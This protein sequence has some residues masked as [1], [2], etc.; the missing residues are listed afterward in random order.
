MNNS[1]ITAAVSM[2][3]IQQRLDIISDNIAN[4]NTA[5]YKSKG[6]TFE[7]TLTEVVKQQKGMSLT[8]RGTPLGTQAAYGTKMTG[9]NRNF[10]QGPIQV[11]DNPTDLAI[12]GNALFAVQANGQKAWTRE[13][14][15]QI[16]P[17]PSNEKL[18]YLTTA[19][20]YYVLDTNGAP[21]SI[22]KGAK[23]SIDSAGT[24]KAQLGSTS[25][26]LGRI[27]LAAPIKTDAL[28]QRADNL[29]VLAPGATEKD[30]LTAVDALPASERA[31]L[32]QGALEQSN[33]D[34]TT[35]MSTMLQ[36]QRAY[37]LSAKAL[38]SSD[39][40]SSLVNNLRG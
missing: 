30:V 11:T 1:M 21:I 35:E 40:M 38:T 39:T 29:Y 6:A 26:T 19:Q 7:D 8:G 18:A 13:G 3:S 17:D 24:V 31:S 36:V 9:V 15:F 34:L 5:G 2:G 14:D 10:A 33:V 4:V 28:E 37:Q 23:L 16:H 22:P 27:Q 20:G 25:A 12:E 32:R